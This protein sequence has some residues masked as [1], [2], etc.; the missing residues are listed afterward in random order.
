M[1]KKLAA[2][3]EYKSVPNCDSTGRQR[4]NLT[5]ALL[6]LLSLLPEKEAQP[7]ADEPLAQKRAFGIGTQRCLPRNLPKKTAR[8]CLGP[9]LPFSKRTHRRHRRTP[10]IPRPSPLLQTRAFNQFACEIFDV[11]M[12]AR[13]YLLFLQI[14][15]FRKLFR[16]KAILICQGDCGSFFPARRAEAPLDQLI[17]G[18]HMRD[19]SIV[20]RERF[21][22][23]LFP[24][25][26][27]CLSADSI[28]IPQPQGYVAFRA[29]LEIVLKGQK[30]SENPK[31]LNTRGDHVEKQRLELGL[32]LSEIAERLRV[33]ETSVYNRE[34]NRSVHGICFMPA[35]ADFL[36]YAPAISSPKTFGEKKRKH[37]IEHGLSHKRLAIQLRIDPLTVRRLESNKGKPTRKI[38]IKILEMLG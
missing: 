18:S 35:I 23:V 13:Y 11:Q 31:V 28:Q 14:F 8:A 17:S 20:T 25:G 19:G 29:S 34:R 1:S 9:C 30:T 26:L 3:H 22:V 38:M 4:L 10:P 16:G 32:L 2:K 6:P 36:S 5:I 15:T 33:N 21:S 37:G 24:V 12:K 7:K 27:A